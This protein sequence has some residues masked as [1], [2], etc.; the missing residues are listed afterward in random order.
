[1]KVQSRGADGETA[2]SSKGRWY[3]QCSKTSEREEV[4]FDFDTYNEDE[5]KLGSLTN[6]FSTSTQSLTM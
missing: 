2:K 6:A 1:M 5:T 3:R 4:A